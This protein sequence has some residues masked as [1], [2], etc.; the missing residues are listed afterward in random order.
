M[1]IPYPTILAV[2][3]LPAICSSAGRAQIITGNAPAPAQLDPNSDPRIKLANRFA[4]YYMANRM[5]ECLRDLTDL[6]TMFEAMFNEDWDRSPPEEQ[7]RIKELYLEAM[8]IAY[9]IPA[10]QEAI[11]VSNIY[12]VESDENK[13]K[14]SLTFKRGS[15]M[16]RYML[17]MHKLL[18][19]WK[20]VDGWAVGTDGW[21][22]NMRKPYARV[23]GDTTPLGFM[24]MINKT[25]R[26]MRAGTAATQPVL[27]TE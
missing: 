16:T 4:E 18:G 26:D 21:V 5:D 13:A 22:E 9:F 12:V 1:R 15:T 14:V 3:V 10:T 19:E 11:S 24:R 27:P 23:R 2:L 6:P 25:L 20:L 8:G 7:A 17:R